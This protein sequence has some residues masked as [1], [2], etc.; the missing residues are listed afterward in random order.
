VTRSAFERITYTVRIRNVGQA[1]AED[2]YV[3]LAERLP[4]GTF[5]GPVT[6]QHRVGA[7]KPQDGWVE[8][9][10]AQVP[11]AGGGRRRAG[12][13]LADWTDGRG[14]QCGQDIGPPEASVVVP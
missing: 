6:P 11:S 9:K 1:A 4:D 12:A 13:V 2:V 7:I 10:H 5:S 8:W 14:E 3:W